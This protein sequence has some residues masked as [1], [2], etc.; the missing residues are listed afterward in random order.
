MGS[1]SNAFKI[2]CQGFMTEFI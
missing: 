2:S 1:Q